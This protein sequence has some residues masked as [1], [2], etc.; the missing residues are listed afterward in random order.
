MHSS[1][2]ASSMDRVI[3]IVAPSGRALAASARRG[4]L[5]PRVVDFFGD[6]DTLALAES[7]RRLPDGLT[8]GMKRGAV[9]DALAA[10][11]D[12][13]QPLGVICGGGFEDRPE[14]LDEIEHAWPLLGNGAEVVALVKDPI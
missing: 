3:L 12:G 4:G 7:H 14:L 2:R 5:V 10:L 9:M 13:S 6:V 11:A 1:S 8:A